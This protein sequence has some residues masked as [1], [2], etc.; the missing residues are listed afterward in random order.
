MSE[1]PTTS[2]GAH[3]TASASPGATRRAL[4]GSA[5]LAP[6]DRRRRGTSMLETALVLPVILL[7]LLGT[8][9]FGLVLARYQIV[10]ASTREGARVGSL[11][12]VDCNPT[13]VR[14][15]VAKTISKTGSHLGMLVLPSDVKL[16]GACLEGQ[17]VEVE[18]EYDHYLTFV[19][20]I[21]G[22]DMRLPLRA[23]VVMRNETS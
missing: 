13:R 9:E 3:P 19:G 18:V 15:D 8:M 14:Q 1:V 16:T 10:L 6:N 7:I 22:G 23:R 4:P 5:S 21:L 20:G 17:N 11:Y 12:R 2:G